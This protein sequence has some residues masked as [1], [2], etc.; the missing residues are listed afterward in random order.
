MDYWILLFKLQKNKI[1][2]LGAK[3]NK[4]FLIIPER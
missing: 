3:L 1:V 4:Q 2:A